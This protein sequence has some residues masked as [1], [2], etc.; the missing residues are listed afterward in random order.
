MKF[1]IMFSLFAL[2]SLSTL[3]R[4]NM[5]DTFSPNSDNYDEQNLALIS[6]TIQSFPLDSLSE[7]E[8]SGLVLMR[9]EEKLARD[10]YIHLYETWGLRIF[11]NISNS[12]S[13]HM[14]A[15][16][17]ILDRYNLID[18]ITDDLVGDFANEELS[19]LYHTL[20]AIGDSS[21]TQAL[22]VG[23]TIEDLDIKDLMDLTLVSDNE[24]ILYTYDNLTR[25]SRN[26]IRSFT[27]QLARYDVNYD[28]QFISDSL[29]TSIL[30]A[31]REIGNW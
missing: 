23:A 1:S 25:G 7:T 5:G 3:S 24:D 21:L 9:E 4:C 16:K 30:L 15:I 13:T 11:N 2:V 22:S 27:D 18:P 14:Y 29:L 28:A 31:N 10:V 6:E 19:E 17:V 26:H 20:T 8:I 12:E